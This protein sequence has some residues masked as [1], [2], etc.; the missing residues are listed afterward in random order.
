[1]GSSFRPSRDALGDLQAA[2]L[3]E[4]G[5]T[6]VGNMDNSNTWAKPPLL[7]DEED[8]KLKMRQA[9]ADS[10]LAKDNPEAYQ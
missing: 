9:I 3:K 1:M 5:D 8:R 4:L 7:A 10:D 6:P 2:W